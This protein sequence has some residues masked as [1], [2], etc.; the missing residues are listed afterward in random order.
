M[1]FRKSLQGECG[2]TGDLG[3]DC[4]VH[5]L[6]ASQ[7]EGNKLVLM[8]N[9]PRNFVHPNGGSYEV[10]AI[11][12]GLVSGY[13]GSCST[14]RTAATD[15]EPTLPDATHF[16]RGTTDTQKTDAAGYTGPATASHV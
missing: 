16:S 5:L 7:S 10:R 9:H 2:R 8:R 1:S 6:Q 14:A 13:D 15:D 11:L 3:P 12:C 4:L